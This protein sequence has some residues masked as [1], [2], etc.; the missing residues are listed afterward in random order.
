MTSARW[1]RLVG[2]VL[3]GALLASAGAVHAD[4]LPLE[5]AYAVPVASGTSEGIEWQLGVYRHAGLRCFA[6]TVPNGPSPG[7]GFSCARDVDFEFWSGMSAFQLT[8]SAGGTA[9]LGY[10]VDGRVAKLKLKLPWSTKRRGGEWIVAPRHTLTAG[11]W[12]S[13]RFR[14]PVSVA[15]AAVPGIS[16]AVGVPCIERIIALSHSGRRLGVSLPIDCPPL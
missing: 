7:M 1:R 9:L 5:P 16:R 3:T 11:E 12:K 6:S 14:S 8:D 10:F 13:A 15:V 2:S 4:T